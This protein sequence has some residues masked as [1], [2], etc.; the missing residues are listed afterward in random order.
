[1]KWS[2]RTCNKSSTIQRVI[3]STRL[4]HRDRVLLTL[5]TESFVQHFKLNVNDLS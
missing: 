2:I 1:M 5:Y 4:Y 3:E